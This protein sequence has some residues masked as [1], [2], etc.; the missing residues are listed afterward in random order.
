MQLGGC[1]P[2]FGQLAGGIGRHMSDTVPI[3]PSHP[4]P[5]NVANSMCHRTAQRSNAIN[6]FPGQI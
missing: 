6:L 3:V 5:V 1:Q 2:L 4:T